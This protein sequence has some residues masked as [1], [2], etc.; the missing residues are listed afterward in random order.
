M[1]ICVFGDTHWSTYS[2]ILRSRGVKYSARLENLINSLNWVQ[3]ISEEENCDEIVGLGDLFDSCNLK[4]EEISALKEVKWNKNIPIHL[5]VGNHESDVASLVFTSTDVFNN[6]NFIIENCVKTYDLNDNQDITFIPYTVEDNRQPLKSYF[7]DQNKK[8]IVF[9]HNDIKGIRYGLF[10]SKE[11]FDLKDIEEHCSLFVNGHLHN[12]TFLNENETI[13]NL[14]NLSGQN[15]TEDATIYPHVIL[16]LDTD[17]LSL[18]FFE[19][20]YAFNFYKIEI[21]KKEDLLKLENLK[22]NAVLSIKC[23][24][25]LLDEV[26]GKIKTIPNIV[27]SKIVIMRTLTNSNNA[28]IE[29]ESTFSNKDYLEQFASFV[30]EKLG[31]NDI[32]NYELSEVCK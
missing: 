19:N 12:G 24:D 3:K 18:K 13:L 2:S 16:I 10:E 29:E 31:V 28:S 26:R 9:S 11:G 8:H 17:D 6:R 14:G 15:F 27:E 30:K 4:A 22:N 20:P 21:T 7:K 32:V 23:I 25:V 5:L 1:K